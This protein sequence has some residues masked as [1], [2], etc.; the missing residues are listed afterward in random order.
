MPE[1]YDGH[2]G[3]NVALYAGTCD[4]SWYFDLAS[5]PYLCH[6]P[7]KK[8]RKDGIQL[9]GPVITHSGEGTKGFKYP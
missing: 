6:D 2:F 8:M 7:K 5:C 9:M 1:K 4:L 3:S